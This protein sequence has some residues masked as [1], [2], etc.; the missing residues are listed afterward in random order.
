MAALVTVPQSNPT[1]FIFQQAIGSLAIM[2]VIQW[3]YTL[4][5]LGLAIILYF[6]I[7]QVSPGLPPGKCFHLDRSQF[8]LCFSCMKI[9]LLLIG[10][11]AF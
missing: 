1:F 10:V 9:S 8:T 7:G 2:F 4:V 3:I 11:N 5:N 6:Y